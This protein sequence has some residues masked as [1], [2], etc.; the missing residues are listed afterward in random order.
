MTAVVFLICLKPENTARPMMTEASAQHD[1]SGAGG[2]VVLHKKLGIERAGN[3]YE[4]VCE[5]KPHDFIGTRIP[6]ERNDQ[7]FV[8]ACCAKKI[9]ELGF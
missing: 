3:G 9:A 5:R 4:A 1:F 7:C 2:I 8:V 6:S